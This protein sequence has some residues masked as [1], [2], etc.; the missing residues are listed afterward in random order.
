MP[1]SLHSNLVRYDVFK[2]ATIDSIL[3]T[4]SKEVCLSILAR[5]FI[6]R[7]YPEALL[8]KDCKVAKCGCF[9]SMNVLPFVVIDCRTE[10]EHKAGVLPNTELLNCKAYSNVDYLQRMPEEYAKA[11][12]VYHILLM[13][14]G[15][16]RFKSRE[17]LG[18]HTKG[19]KD[20]KVVEEEEED[21]VQHMLENLLQVFLYYG[22][23]YVS[24]VEGGFQKVH[25]FAMHYQLQIKNHH[26]DLCM[27]C[28]PDRKKH[29]NKISEGLMKIK[30]RLVGRVKALSLAVKGIGRS[31][32]VSTHVDSE[33]M[34]IKQRK[35]CSQRT[36]LKNISNFGTE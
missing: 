23:P 22:F 17:S 21:Y 2:L 10:A 24:V 5:D 31:D 29:N 25:E 7:I 11:R 34:K 27:V 12:G 36:S 20:E 9:P 13:G 32:L 26:P 30:D 35:K 14:S 4:L 8:C 33:E 19:E 3:N 15:T 18:N 28:N 6:Q 16:F 1:Y